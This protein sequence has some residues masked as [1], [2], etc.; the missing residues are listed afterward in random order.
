VSQPATHDSPYDFKSEQEFRQRMLPQAQV[1]EQF[2]VPR[3][4]GIGTILI[5][6]GAASVL[7]A[8]LVACGVPAP[9][10]F[11]LVGF[12]ALIAFAQA[13]L[14]RGKNPRRASIVAGAI[15]CPV[16]AITASI[17]LMALTDDLNGRIDIPIYAIFV[18]VLGSLFG[19]LAGGVVGGIFL[20]MDQWEQRFGHEVVV[21]HFDPFAPKDRS[22]KA[23]QGWD[24]IE[25]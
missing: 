2:G 22:A 11:H 25:D 23:T 8:F 14:Y 6:M 3:R 4:F 20:I 17:I 16:Y 12:L 21:L 9:F 10:V 24:M 18:S 19:Y 15:V 5:V 1:V 13:I 7:L